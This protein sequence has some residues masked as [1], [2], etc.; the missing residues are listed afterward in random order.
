[1]GRLRGALRMAAASLREVAALFRGLFTALEEQS[2][3][4]LQLQLREMENAF[5]SL[6]LGGMVGLPL[7][8]MGL[9]AELAPLLR[10][11]VR[12]MERMHF[13]GADVLADYF[14]SLGGEW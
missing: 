7:V 10:E 6:V 13:L 1:M 14:S 4:T 9:A 11:E 8:P 12:V 3:E 5:L 2:V